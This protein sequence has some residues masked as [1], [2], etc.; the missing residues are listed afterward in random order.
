VG[1]GQVALRIMAV[2]TSVGRTL[3]AA[4]REGGWVRVGARLAVAGTDHAWE[5]RGAA[6]L[7]PEE[8]EAG[9][10]GLTLAPLGHEAPLRPGMRL[11]EV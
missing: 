10:L 7:P 9:H 2:R 6:Y 5:V 1:R 11:V 4:R 8:R 3:V